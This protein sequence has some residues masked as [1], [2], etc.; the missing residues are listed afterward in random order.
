MMFKCNRSPPI[1]VGHEPY[2]IATVSPTELPE[3][4]SALQSLW[5]KIRADSAFLALKQ[6]EYRP[7]NYLSV[8]AVM[9]ATEQL[10]IE[11]SL[12]CGQAFMIQEMVRHKKVHLDVHSRRIL[13]E[14]LE[15]SR[16]TLPTT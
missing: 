2:P 9:D 12:L 11:R 14:I 8:T 10:R 6:S 3:M 15:C 13:Q 16:D 5:E 7:D 1:C 4:I